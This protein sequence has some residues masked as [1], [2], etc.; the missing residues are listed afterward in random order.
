METRTLVLGK[1][2]NVITMVLDNLYSH[3]IERFKDFVDDVVVYNNL[4][5]PILNSFDH[6]KF[7]IEVLNEVNIDDF[8]LYVLGVYQPKNKIKILESLNPDKNKFIN[9]IHKGEDISYTSTLGYGLL[10]NSKVS[11]AAHT[12]IGNFVTINRHVSIGHHTTIGDFT[13]INPGV[14]IAGNV[15]IGKGC[16]IGIGANIIDGVKIGDNTIIGAGSVVT[17]DI[18]SDVIAYGSPCKIIKENETQSI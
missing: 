3:S 14:N 15:T 2:D 8:D 6:S 11:I 17:K 13:S 1:G 16:Q 10:I 7:N 4:D 12:T 9:V 5:L 18:P